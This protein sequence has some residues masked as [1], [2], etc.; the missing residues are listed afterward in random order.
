MTALRWLLPVLAFACGAA[1]ADMPVL[2][3]AVVPIIGQAAFLP[4]VLEPFLTAHGARLVMT[5]THGR[6]VVRAARAGETDLIVIHARFKALGKLRR[7]AVIGSPVPV[8]ANPIALLA[9][10]GDPAHV[11]DAPDPATAMARIKATRACLLVNALGGLEDI[12]R[13]LWGEGGCLLQQADAV[14]LGAVLAA[15]RLGAYTWWGLHPFVNSAQPMIP[16]VWSTPALHR[17]LVAAPV[18]G[19]PA[20]ALAEAAIAWLNSPDGRKA[21]AAFRLPGHPAVQAFWPPTAEP[22]STEQGDPD[23]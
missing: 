8:F 17:T 14:G 18:A 6:E 23:E 11:A 4:T 2:R 5:A 3:A 10:P 22:A 20:H 13:S 12:Q 16:R 19:A 7:E 1:R 21:V 9:P 15:Q